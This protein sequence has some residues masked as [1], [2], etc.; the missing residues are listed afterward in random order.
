MRAIETTYQGVRY[1]SRL[2]ARWAVV[3]FTFGWEYIYEPEGFEHCGKVYLPDFWV[4]EM[5]AYVEIKPSKVSSHDLARVTEWQESMRA[6]GGRLI[7]LRGEPMAGRYAIRAPGE[8]SATF[9]DCRRCDGVS[10]VYTDGSGWG[11]YIGHACGGKSEKE[12]C[13]TINVEKAFYAAMN[14][15]FNEGVTP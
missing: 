7:L 11:E 2:E 1:R 5:D 6:S 12:P 10:F 4:K 8:T 13:L 9:F 15:R 3:F 14:H